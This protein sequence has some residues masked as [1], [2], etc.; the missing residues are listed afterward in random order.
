MKTNLAF[1]WA[2]LCIGGVAPAATLTFEGEIRRDDELV[3]IWFRPGPGA[4]R[5][6]TTS[7]AVGGFDPALSV[8][9]P[10]G[11][12]IAFNQDSPGAA[13]DPSTGFAFD[14][15]IVF[16]A[17]PKGRYRAVLS[18]SQN[19]PLGPFYADGFLYAGQPSFTGDISGFPGETCRDLGGNPR[20]CA[21]AVRFEGVEWASPIPEPSTGA[22]L[23]AAGLAGLASRRVSQAPAGVT[24]STRSEDGCSRPS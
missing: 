4:V 22:L 7:Y 17:L 15:E 10:V 14:A 23:L 6:V 11:L 12:L 5:I 1:C 19:T 13:V 8:F 3:R 9:D 21:W 18:Q 24:R 2:L 20:T 16:P